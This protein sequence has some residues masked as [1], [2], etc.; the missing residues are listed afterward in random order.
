MIPESTWG[1]EFT[2]LVKS[3]ISNDE[4]ILST[5]TNPVFEKVPSAFTYTDVNN[6]LSN[7]GLSLDSS[8]GVISGTFKLPTNASTDYYEELHT[9][10]VQAVGTNNLITPVV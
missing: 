9:I 6:G 1:S 5:V 2:A 3:E 10:T 7:L 4:T 8:T